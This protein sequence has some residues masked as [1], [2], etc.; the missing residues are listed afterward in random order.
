VT[1]HVAARKEIRNLHGLVVVDVVEVSEEFFF[2]CVAAYIMLV[3][4]CSF[5]I[6]GT[7][8]NREQQWRHWYTCRR[9]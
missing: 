2:L 3:P 7:F 4:S 5:L 8:L 6:V 1:V 9:S